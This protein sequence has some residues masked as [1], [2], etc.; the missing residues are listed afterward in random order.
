MEQPHYSMPTT[1]PIVYSGPP[2]TVDALSGHLQGEDNKMAVGEDGLLG[3]LQEQNDEGKLEDEIQAGLDLIELLQQEAKEMEEKQTMGSTSAPAQQPYFPMPNL[4]IPAVTEPWQF[5]PINQ[6]H[7]FGNV[8]GK[9]GK[10]KLE[11]EI[12][13]GLDLIELLQ[14]EAKEMEEKMTMGSA[15]APAQQP[16]LPMPPNAQHSANTEPIQPKVSPTLEDAA[17]ANAQ[18]SSTPLEP[19]SSGPDTGDNGHSS[20]VIDFGVVD[21]SPASET[22]IS[23]EDEETK[24]DEKTAVLFLREIEDH[25]PACSAYLYE[26]NSISFRRSSPAVESQT[27]AIPIRNEDKE[28]K[29]QGQILSLELQD[30]SKQEAAFSAGT[31]ETEDE[32]IRKLEEILSLELEN[33]NK[34]EATSSAG[35][36]E[37]EDITVID[38]GVAGRSRSSAIVI[39][40]DDNQGVTSRPRPKQPVFITIEDDDAPI[41]P[42]MDRRRRKNQDALEQWGKAKNLEKGAIK[43]LDDLPKDL[44][45]GGRRDYTIS[46]TFVAD[47][48][49][50]DAKKEAT[51]K[52][53]LDKRQ[54]AAE[55]RA[56]DRAAKQAEKQADQLR[57]KEQR[58]AD[59]MSRMAEQEEERQR[60][61]ADRLAK[62]ANKHQEHLQWPLECPDDFDSWLQT[63]EG[64]EAGGKGRMMARL[65]GGRASQEELDLIKLSLGSG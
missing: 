17:P 31:H 20:T 10:G 57:R 45:V 62:Q 63:D 35:P 64:K 6:N 9:N 1:A 38:S 39:D 7:P 19:S 53:N 55:A 40:Y 24:R 22:T 18:P 11:D 51:A 12:Q 33:D 56:Q 60:R 4:E 49:R 44:N 13:A 5:S 15:S 48:E 37:T 65:M 25:E 59:R 34:Q 27:S 23:I 30:Y 42:E 8:Q 26:P 14:Q 46:S 54:A 58:E 16:Y 21:N 47:Y 36:H 50:M 52:K 43:M 3:H 41:T 2:E 28:I 29:E 32:M 61:A